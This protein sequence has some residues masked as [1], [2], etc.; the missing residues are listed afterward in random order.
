MTRLVA[1]SWPSCGRVAM[2]VCVVKE[3]GREGGEGQ[4]GGGGR[5]CLGL[6]RRFK[7]TMQE[8]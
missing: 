3:G 8:K 5:C 2:A 1:W 7:R 4:F 6:G